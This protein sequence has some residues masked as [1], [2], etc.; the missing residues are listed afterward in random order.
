MKILTSNKNKLLEFQRILKD[1]NIEVAT[2]EDLEEV[3]G[4]REEVI[5]YKS[6][7]AGK[8]VMVEDTILSVDGK[9]VVDIRFKLEEL[10]NKVS[11][12]GAITKLS[13]IVNLGYNDGSYIYI[14]TGVVDG[15]FTQKT[16]DG[17]GFDPYFLPNWANASLAQLEKE[18]RKDD[19]SARILALNNFMQKRFTKKIK[20]KD[21][22][23]WDGAY[24][25]S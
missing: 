16:T 10:L 4:N 7:S 8:D 24:Q 2:G 23:K 3:L 17:F 11:R 14:Y 6:L 9:D 18:G 20:I 22:P 5:T 12:Y 25:N 1:N 19:Y 13:W 15:I 21:I